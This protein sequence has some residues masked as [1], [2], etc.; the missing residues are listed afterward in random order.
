MAFTPRRLM[1]GAGSPAASV[2]AQFNYVTMLLH[3]DG[4][5]GARNNTFLDSS[6]NTF[7]ITQNGNTS[8]GSF[9]PYGPNWSNFFGGSSSITAPDSSAFDYGS[10]DFTLECWIFPTTTNSSTLLTAQTSGGIYGPCNLFFSS[11]ALELYSSSNGS[12]FDVASGASVGT[13]AVNQWS[14]VAVSRSGTSIRC[15]LNGTVTSTTTSS[16]TLMNATGTFQIASRNG[17]EFYSGYV[18]NFRV[19][20]GTAVYTGSFTPST[21]PLTAIS[22]T[23]LLTCADNRFLDDSTNNFTITVNGTPS[24]QRFNPF[25]TATAYS[26]AVIGGSAYIDNNGYLGC[27]SQSAYALGTGDFTINAWIYPTIATNYTVILDT[28][29]SGGSAGWALA[30]DGAKTIYFYSAVT[31]SVVVTSVI[32]AVNLNAWT[33]VTVTRTSGT[34]RLYLNGVLVNTASNSD[35]YSYNTLTCGYSAA[36]GVERYYGYMS[37]VQVI[38]GTAVAPTLPTAPV[39]TS[40]G[41]SVLLNFQNGAIFDNAMMNDLETTANGTAQI[42]TSVVKYGTGSINNNGTT[43]YPSGTATKLRLRPNP[44]FSFGTGDFTVEG[45][46]YQTT[47]GSTY[48]SILEINNHLGA[49]GILFIGNTSGVACVYAAGTGGGGFVAQ[50]ATTAN[51]WQHIAFVRNNGTL[52]TYVNGVSTSSKTGFTLN[53]QCTTALTI[54]GE[55]TNNGDY[56]YYGYIDDFRVTRYAR[57]TANFTPPTKAFFDTGPV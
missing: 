34:N 53:I 5:N 50:Q 19:V 4:T 33:H 14:H 38:K 46:F 12:S 55:F 17:S 36:G 49:D 31:F 44:N 24:V 47:I 22:G 29:G 35:N 7:S 51:V 56:N 18:S 2:D 39:A 21:T 9:S 48:Q 23:S 10:G 15:F 42:S 54:G 1:Q 27:G 8:Q 20:K 45:W 6:T 11:G 41:T 32:G 43:S 30:M 40:G 13:P 16:A 3:G 57:Y 26:T 52:R 37:D 25:G 28:R